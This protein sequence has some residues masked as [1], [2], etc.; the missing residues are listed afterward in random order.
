[1]LE[2]GSCEWLGVLFTL[3]FSKPLFFFLL[4]RKEEEEEG[5]GEKEEGGRPP[6]RHNQTRNILTGSRGMGRS[7][8]NAPLTSLW[9]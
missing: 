8:L 4:K 6:P 7:C 1:M 5:E 3:L 2:G 9:L